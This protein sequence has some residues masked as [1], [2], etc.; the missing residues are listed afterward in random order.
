MDA[1]Y[2]HRYEIA[3][4]SGGSM[5]TYELTQLSVT[6][7]FLRLSLPLIRDMSWGVALPFMAGRGFRNLLATAERSAH[8][9]GVPHPV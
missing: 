5:V 2:R 4:A 3:P 7:P 9:A 6:N 8:P 1:T